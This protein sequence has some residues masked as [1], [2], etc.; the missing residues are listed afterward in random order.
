MTAFIDAERAAHGVE[1]ICNVVPIAPS[2]YYARKARQ[3]GFV[4]ALYRIGRMRPCVSNGT[5]LW[6]G[7][8]LRLG[9][10]SEIT[11]LRS[12]RGSAARTGNGVTAAAR[13]ACSG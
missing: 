1:P 4:S 12:L 2:T 8:V 13:Q 6:S 10:P 7:L 11:E 5:G 9:H 3:A